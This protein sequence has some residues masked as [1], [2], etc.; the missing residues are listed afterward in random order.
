MNPYRISSRPSPRDGKQRRTAAHRILGGTVVGALAMAAVSL[1]GGGTAFAWSNG[2]AP[3][4]S[5][6]GAC[7][8]GSAQTL[9]LAVTIQNVE[10]GDPAY[11]TAVS[12][13][14]TP[15]A[16]VT[17]VSAGGL[18]NGSIIP[19]GPST[20]TYHQVLTAAFSSP[21]TSAQISLDLAANWGSADPSTFHYLAGPV[22]VTAACQKP[23][24]S[25][26]KTGSITSYTAAG[27][28][29]TY[30][31]VVKNTGNVTLNPVTV[32]DPMAG[33]SKISCPDQS[34]TP[35]ETETCTAR[36]ITTGTDVTNRSIKNTGTAIGTPP[37][38]PN[39]SA[40]SSVTIPGTPPKS[41]V[42]TTTTTTTTTVPPSPVTVPSQP[43][44]VA[45]V[46]TVPVTATPA[47]AAST[48]TPNEA[49]AFTGAPVGRLLGIATLL[50]LVGLGILSLERIY[51]RR[52]T[53]RS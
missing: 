23:G 51:R 4:L 13:A 22:T 1:V 41:T 46:A 26:I 19:A 31:Y 36:Y 7:A 10:T 5:V 40:T 43:K 37:T 28:L 6:S 45:A 20:T 15:A 9:D 30:S 21:T 52:R 12:Y 50:V 34:L 49:L 32:S 16:T 8:A 2:L 17:V 27:T 11:V 35:N 3:T 33:L 47:G 18:T 39:V 38:G 42:V 29:V 14:T 48:A 44:K 24:I 53:A 25:L